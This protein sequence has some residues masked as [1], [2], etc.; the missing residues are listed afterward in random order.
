MLAASFDFTMDEK[1][2]TPATA[3]ASPGVEESKKRASFG[4]ERPVA[5]MPLTPEPTPEPARQGLGIHS[6]Q[7]SSNHSRQASA[8]G[9]SPKEHV[10]DVKNREEGRHADFAN[11]DVRTVFGDGMGHKAQVYG[12][13]IKGANRGGG[14][15]DD[16]DAGAGIGGAT[17]TTTKEWDTKAPEQR[18]TIFALRMAIIEKAASRIGTLS[19]LW[20]TVVILGGFAT[21]VNQLDFRVVTIIILAES[22]RIFS[23]SHELELLQMSVLSRESLGHRFLHHAKSSLRLTLFGRCKRRLKTCLASTD[24]AGHAPPSH[25]PTSARHRPSKKK[26][27]SLSSPSGEARVRN[28]PSTSK[29]ISRLLYAVQIVFA[30]ATVGLALWRLYENDYFYNPNDNLPRPPNINVSMTVFYVLSIAEAMLFLLERAFWELRMRYGKILD[31]VNDEVGL[32]PEN[33]ESVRQF[34]IDVYS[35]CLKGSV[36]DGLEMDL[37]SFAIQW[38]RE[39][40]YKQQLGGARL[41]KSIVSHSGKEEETE[42]KKELR[43]LNY[44]AADCLRRLG[45][46]PGVIE[47]LVEMLSWNGKDEEALLVEVAGIV[48]RLVAYNR[49]ASRIVAIPGAVDGI[50]SLL[51]HEYPRSNGRDHEQ[52]AEVYL[53]L[54]VE[55]LRILKYLCFDHNNRITIGE[56]RGVLSILIVFCVAPKEPSFSEGVNSKLGKCHLKTYKKS[57]QILALLASAP[58]SS[59]GL[60]RRRIADVVSGLK[61]LRDIIQFDKEPKLQKMSVEIVYHLALDEGVRIT[62]GSTGGVISSL[63][64]LFSRYKDLEHNELPSERQQ[65]SLMAGKALSRIL[66]QN[67]KNTLKTITLV[68]ENRMPFLEVMMHF[69]WEPLEDLL[70]C[71][72]TRDIATC[73]AQILRT[74]FEFVEASVQ[75][76]LARGCVPLV[77]LSIDMRQNGRSSLYESY[78]GLITKVLDRLDKEA[79]QQA[80]NQINKQEWMDQLYQ[81]LRHTPTTNKYPSI[82]RYTIELLHVIAERDVPHISFYNVIQAKKTVNSTNICD[83]LHRTADSIS[84]VE[85]FCLFSG[86]IGY[87]RHHEEMEELV[88]RV[89]KIMDMTYRNRSPA[90]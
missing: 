81:N 23:R 34:F 70:N 49:N 41:L 51:L 75:E 38:L 13:R 11:I 77:M 74:V 83:E 26:P 53:E 45:T 62:I 73:S 84:E 2:S 64:N 10:V 30:V 25:S 21:T 78:L 16:D 61:N 86:L 71:A 29:R 85:N 88:A 1:A 63:F 67:E 24:A 8:E 79:Y 65:A 50:I 82:R 3:A 5:P 14:G 32:G 19:F 31:R 39:E 28:A 87:T 18:I 17:T 20:A 58:N 27:P 72:A 22:S 36:F 56:T 52:M 15:D 68:S 33:L 89:I 46:A 4:R 55:A 37:V 7:N 57:L 43:S 35:A 12:E 47:R 40:D 90:A 59:G 60:L 66:L 9:K 76:K 6:R 54:R 42:N 80:I 69:L 48:R 44:F